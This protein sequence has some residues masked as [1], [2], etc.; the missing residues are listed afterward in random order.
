MPMNASRVPE[1][2]ELQPTVA[3]SLGH[4]RRR[5]DQTTTPMIVCRFSDQSGVAASRNAASGA[6]RLA[7]RAGM[8]AAAA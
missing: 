7:R 5:H 6:T 3:Q 8:K 2:E 1:P 4:R